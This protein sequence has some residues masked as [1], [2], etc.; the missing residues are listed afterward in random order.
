MQKYPALFEGTFTHR[1]WRVLKRF[2][3]VFVKDVNHKHTFSTSKGDNLQSHTYKI[4]YAT[5]VRLAL[6]RRPTAR[7]GCGRW[8]PKMPQKRFKIACNSTIFASKLRIFGANRATK[9]AHTHT[10][11]FSFL[12]WT[13]ASFSALRTD[14]AQ[15]SGPLRAKIVAKN[16][17]NAR[18]ST[19]ALRIFGA[20]WLTTAS[21]TCKI[22]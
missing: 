20:N 3:E 14:C 11:F 17:Q 12:W 10:F 7:K 18:N 4:V 22:V 15:V 1:F 5:L 6:R 2:F 8:A 19:F 16:L 13:V 9:A 21:H